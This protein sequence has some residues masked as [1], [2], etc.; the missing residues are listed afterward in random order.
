MITEE[1]SLSLLDFFRIRQK[2]ADYC[3]SPEGKTLMASTLPCSNPE[4][5]KCLQQDLTILLDICNERQL[6]ALSFPVI[7]G[8]LV[9]LTKEGATLDEEELF[10]LGLW[11]KSYERFFA[12]LRT[13]L[14]QK[15]SNKIAVKSKGTATK[16]GLEGVPNPPLDLLV[17]DARVSIDSDDEV[18]ARIGIETIVH[19]APR[20]SKVINIIFSV[21]TDDGQLQDLPRFKSIK[22]SI[23][24]VQIENQKLIH[25]YLSNPQ[26]R[27][28]LQ[29]TEP[30]I[31]DNRTVL[32]IKAN[33][34]GRVRG[35]VHEYSQS[36]QTLF[37]EP[38]ELVAQN[39]KL[40]EL[41]NRLK[42]R[43]SCGIEGDERCAQAIF[44]SHL[45]CSAA[46]SR[47]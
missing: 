42:H 16:A 28:V 14:A 32:A 4:S 12:F 15:H 45:C 22:S 30:T 36:G 25:R 9:K 10:A 7:E 46:S 2:L 41:E 26:L 37:I 34:K 20:L 31:R 47:C 38:F 11:A 17:E 24:A 39:N 33:Y 6:P 29:S 23:Q 43:N 8:V 13:A 5:V 40:I 35:I 44:A 1:H 19:E 27:D 21:L 18:W 3:L